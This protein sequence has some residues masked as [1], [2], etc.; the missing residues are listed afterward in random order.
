MTSQKTGI[1]GEA[2]FLN[3]KSMK[4]SFLNFTLRLEKR[5]LRLNFE[6]KAIQMTIQFK[7]QTFFNL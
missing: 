4:S 7:L 2:E 1:K 3:P 5:V 6:G